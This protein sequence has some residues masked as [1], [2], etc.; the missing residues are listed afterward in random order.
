MQGGVERVQE[1][2]E[3]ARRGGR[4]HDGVGPVAAAENGL[5]HGFTLDFLRRDDAQQRAGCRGWRARRP[6]LASTVTPQLAVGGDQEERELRLG[7]WIGNQRNRGATLSPERMELLSAIGMRWTW[8]R[9][10]PAAPAA[11]SALHRVCRPNREAFTCREK[12]APSRS[13]AYV[14]NRALRVSPAP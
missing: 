7:A 3:V 9:A 6:A 12:Y 14:V 8:P 4:D 1:R 11:S 5:H 10:G 2:R 13:L